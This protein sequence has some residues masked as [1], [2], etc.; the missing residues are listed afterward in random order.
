ML[1]AVLY[2][3]QNTI[4]ADIDP[5]WGFDA[6][7]T[8]S[9]FCVSNNILFF[10]AI[11][12][13]DAIGTRLWKTDGTVAGTVPIKDLDPADDF[14]PAA[15]ELTDVN[16]TV[17]FATTDFYYSKK[18]WKSDGTKGGTQIL[19]DITSDPDGVS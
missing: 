5:W 11:N 6:D 10:S 3:L 2:I 16:G 14:L 9:F 8:K 18:L 13:F 12:H 1:S 7:N 19:K 17:F 15:I 4:Q